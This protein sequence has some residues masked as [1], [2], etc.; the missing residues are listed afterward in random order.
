[1]ALIKALPKF[2]NEKKNKKKCKIDMSDS[3]QETNH[4]LTPKKGRS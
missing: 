3:E 1:M 4:F 2:R